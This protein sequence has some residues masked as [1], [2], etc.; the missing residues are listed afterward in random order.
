MEGD[1]LGNGGIADVGNW[2]TGNSGRVRNTSTT[3]GAVPANPLGGTR[4]LEISRSVG[5]PAYGVATVSAVDGDAVHFE[6]DM[7]VR[8]VGS[9]GSRNADAFL[10]E[11]SY[12]G[13][14]PL[15]GTF[16]WI[17]VEDSTGPTTVSALTNGGGT[18]EV[19]STN[20]DLNE[21][22]HYELDYIIGRATTMFLTLDG[23]TPI[24]LHKP[25]GRG[26][27]DEI[28]ATEVKGILFRP[29]DVVGNGVQFY[30]DNVV[31]DIYD[32]PM[33]V[34]AGD[35]NSDGYVDTLDLDI[36]N[37]N[38]GNTVTAG[39][40]LQGDTSGDGFVGKE[41]VKI[42]RSEWHQ[43]TDPSPVSVPE[44]SSLALLVLGGLV[45]LLPRRRCR[46]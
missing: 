31:L 6:Y 3:G 7:Y 41:D 28:T 15:N 27:Y 12:P 19:L 16:P 24:N 5:W 23:G 21:W 20:V 42:V 17:R 46:V 9:A 11:A 38:W 33:L 4:F 39:D 35:L 36:L 30:V 32:A 40:K 22:H 26:D 25:W 18:R 10:V 37:A 45:L 43:G 34:L 2:D 29:A 14:H 8:D 1:T 44:P 13:G